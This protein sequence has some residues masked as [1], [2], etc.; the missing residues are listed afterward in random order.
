MISE[1]HQ[2]VTKSLL[3]TNNNSSVLGGSATMPTSYFWALHSD[4]SKPKE[5]D[6]AYIPAGLVVILKGGYPLTLPD[7]MDTLRYAKI[8]YTEV[9][10]PPRPNQT[11]KN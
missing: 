9:K 3:W 2:L 4:I 6:T 8:R 11:R 7:P 1:N 10:N 5:M